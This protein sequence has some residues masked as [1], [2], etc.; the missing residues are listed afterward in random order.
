MKLI[1]NFLPNS[2]FIEIQKYLMG[3]AM[4]WHYQKH[5]TLDSEREDDFYFTHTFY[6]DKHQ[7]SDLFEEI[8][9]PIIGR[10]DFDYL[11]RARARL[12]TKQS[13]QIPHNFHV[14]DNRKHAVGIFSINSNNGY[15]LFE[16]G[17][18]SISKENTLLLFNG[19]LKHATVP[20]TDTS[21]RVNINFN[22]A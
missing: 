8:I 18:K 21:I 7:Q 22:F 9:H 6:A 15:T 11:Y 19:S 20:Q 2:L 14:D 16:N 10:L 4:L 5:T 1:E 13:I 17:E 3:P 12:V